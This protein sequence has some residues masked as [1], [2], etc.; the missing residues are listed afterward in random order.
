MYDLEERYSQCLMDLGKEIEQH[1]KCDEIIRGLETNLQI[2]LDDFYGVLD[3]LK[4]LV[5]ELSDP[6][7]S[8]SAQ[9]TASK[10]QHIISSNR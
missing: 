8:E 9:V 1:I 2:T 10:I 3:A 5:F 6:N 4:D 7:Y